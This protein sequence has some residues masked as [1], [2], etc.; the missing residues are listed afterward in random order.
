MGFPLG[1]A[2]MAIQSYTQ[3]RSLRAFGSLSYS[4]SS[5]QGILA[6]CTLA[7]SMLMVLLHRSV[8]LSVERFPTV[9]P[10]DLMDVV[11]FHWSGRRRQGAFPRDDSR[12][13]ACAVNS[14]CHDI[15]PLG[16]IV[17]ASKSGFVANACSVRDKVA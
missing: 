16:L 4:F 7:T 13:L 1:L 14:L 6:G 2:W 9:D 3:P 12:V 8:S 15:R 5:S 10:R 11:S 17:Q